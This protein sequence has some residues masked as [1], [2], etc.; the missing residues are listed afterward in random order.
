MRRGRDWA[1]H[2]APA[3][4]FVATVASGKSERNRSIT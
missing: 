1:R 2:N 4:V 3:D